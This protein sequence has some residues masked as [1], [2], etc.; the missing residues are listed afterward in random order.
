MILFL[1]LLAG[2]WGSPIG[3][4]NIIV[5]I[6]WIFWWFMLI[7]FLVPLGGRVWCMMCPLPSLGEWLS[8]GKLIGAGNHYRPGG[9]SGPRG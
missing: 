7:T 6:V 4:R 3:N 5:T 2:F 1:F 9:S 8:R